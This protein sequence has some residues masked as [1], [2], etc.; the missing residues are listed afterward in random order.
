MSS[1]SSDTQSSAPDLL[2]GRVLNKR[3][4]LDEPIGCGYMSQVYRGWD[5][6]SAAVRAIKLLRAEHLQ[7]PTLVLRFM[8]EA[9]LLSQL[10]HPNIVT[11][12]EL[13]QEPD[14]TL[15]MVL[16]FL[17]GRDL[18][19]VS[20]LGYYLSWPNAVHVLRQAGSALQS[21]HAAGLVHRDIKLSNLFLVR[22]RQPTGR[23]DEAVVKLIDFGFARPVLSAPRRRGSEGFVL[24]TPPY[25][26]PELMTGAAAT[27]L[28]DQWALGIAAYILL[29]HQHPFDQGTGVG[30]MLCRIRNAELP[31]LR[32]MH[33]DVPVHIE[34][35]IRRA[36][37]KRPEDRFPSVQ[38]FVDAL[39]APDCGFTGTNTPDRTVHLLGKGRCSRL[40]SIVALA[41]SMTVGGSLSA[42]DL[43]IS[44]PAVTAKPS[45]ELN[46][47]ASTPTESAEMGSSEVPQPVENL[48]STSGLVS[49]DPRVPR[50]NRHSQFRVR[51]NSKE[52]ALPVARRPTRSS[53]RSGRK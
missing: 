46:I 42:H 10:R 21:V 37:C 53:A 14:G 30:P 52:T 20:E 31:S 29:S 12:L 47:D 8:D 48:M 23:P 1:L 2:V 7:A 27:P 38:S 9:Q 36:L 11:L 24:C 26:A 15:Y 22:S 4:R 25:V 43:P 40:A 41:G 34:E 28:S 51:R 17:E 16:E 5:Y 44:P 6:S 3:Y 33:P 45:S 39:H 32:I 19:R 35:A 50:C 49:G 13:G 18:F